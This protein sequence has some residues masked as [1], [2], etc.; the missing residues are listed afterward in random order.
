MLSFVSN[1][2]FA[3]I[4]IEVL[5]FCSLYV[6]VTGRFNR[7]GDVQSIFPAYN[8]LSCSDLC[9]PSTPPAFRHDIP[10]SFSDGY[11]EN[12]QGQ[13]SPFQLSFD[14]RNDYKIGKLRETR[15]S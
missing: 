2:D 11:D 6:A 7:V 15:G 3:G 14:R 1:F 12:C 4:Q 13:A 10:S 5:F 8:H 9:F